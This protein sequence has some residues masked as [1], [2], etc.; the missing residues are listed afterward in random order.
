[1]SPN[2]GN[3]TAASGVLEI[4]DAIVLLLGAP[5]ASERD[6]GRIE[7]ITRLEKLLFL[8]EKETDAP[9]WLKEDAGFSSNN[10]GPFSAKAYQEIEMLT[11]AG[12][13]EDSAKLADSS[14]D[15]WETENI[16]GEEPADPYAT[17]NLSLTERGRR[18]YDALLSELPEG[19][20]EAV[21]EIKRRFGSMPLRR[22]IRYV[23]QRYP[24][25]TDK[26]KIRDEILGT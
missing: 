9:N 24:E 23:Y 26:S 11:S 15:T 5:G 14:E 2:T 3:S 17:R 6:R 18:Y 13:V 21:A 10:F 7:G 16:I 20:E 19:A 22:L 4:D 8:L 25:F 12:L 1:M